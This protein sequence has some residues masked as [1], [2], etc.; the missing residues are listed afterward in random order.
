MIFDFNTSSYA[1]L[2]NISRGMEDVFMVPFPWKYI[3]YYKE[4][5]F[6]KKTNVRSFQYYSEICRHVF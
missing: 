6:C 5:I 1:Q 3:L 4:M 2:E